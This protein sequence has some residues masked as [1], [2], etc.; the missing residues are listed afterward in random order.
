MLNFIIK[1][2][3][4]VAICSIIIIIAFYKDESFKNAIDYVK[5]LLGKLK[6]KIKV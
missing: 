1:G 4:M 6:N 3:L 2:I 5:K